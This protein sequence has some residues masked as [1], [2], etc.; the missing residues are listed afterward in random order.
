MLN[1]EN[2]VSLFDEQLASW[3]QAGNNYKA[4]ERVITKE[5]DIDGFPFKVQFNPARIVSSAAK[6][7]NKSIQERKCFLC[8]ENRP[9]VQ[10]GLEYI[11]N[12]DRTDIYTVLVNPF[13]IFPK[14]LTI[15]L[16][17]HKDQAILGRFDA[18][19]D[20]ASLL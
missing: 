11:H 9:A 16:L 8:S 6:V 2:L 20:L 19:A 1:R 4:L 17:A 18:M 13:P 7:D 14:H 12:G 5:V 15:P 10:K 3:E